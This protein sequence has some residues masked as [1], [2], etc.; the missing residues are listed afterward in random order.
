MI[1]VGT[2]IDQAAKDREVKPESIDWPRKKEL[3][4]IEVSA[5]G[6][7]NVKEAL[8]MILKGLLG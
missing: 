6:G 7:W 3:E 4:Y 1:V 5:K 2:K 8:V